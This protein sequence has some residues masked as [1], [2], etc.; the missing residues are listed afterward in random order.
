M[1]IIVRKKN[2]LKMLRQINPYLSGYKIPREILN[3]MEVLLNN[4]N[5]GRNG[6]IAIILEPTNNDGIDILEELNLDRTAVEIPDDN[7]YH[8]VVKGKKHPM[9]RNR[10]WY[11]YDISLND[12]R[13]KVYVIYSMLDSQ[14]KK[15]GVV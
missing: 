13:E 12:N 6:Y 7:F 8:I 4:R 10:K 9:K 11:S 15:L 1:H 5:L 2:E 14:L 3:H